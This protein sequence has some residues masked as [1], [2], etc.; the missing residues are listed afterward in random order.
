M[1]ARDLRDLPEA[2][3]LV[4]GYDPLRDE[5][6]QYAEK[7][8]LAG[9]NTTLINYESMIHGFLS[10]LGILDQAEEAITRICRWL[11]EKFYS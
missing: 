4:S 1:N 11:N 2:L 7:L 10:Y 9:V 8:E 5:G 3:V 6:I